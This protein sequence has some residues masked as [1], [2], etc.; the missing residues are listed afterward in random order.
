MTAVSVE[1]TAAVA[2][3][4]WKEMPEWIPELKS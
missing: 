1:R 3:E 2:L 4:L